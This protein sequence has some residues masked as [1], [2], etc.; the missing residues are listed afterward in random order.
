MKTINHIVFLSENVL[1]FFSVILHFL[2]CP[3]P[4]T[5]TS[6]R[7]DYI[8]ELGIICLLLLIEG[9]HHGLCVVI[10]RLPAAQLPPLWTPI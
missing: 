3:L 6:L 1:K 2:D 4:T 8:R 10:R 7:N 5:K 9:R